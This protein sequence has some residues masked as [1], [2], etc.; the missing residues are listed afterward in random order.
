MLHCIPDHKFINPKKRETSG[1]AF[2]AIKRARKRQWTEVGDAKKI[3]G[4][5]LQWLS[6]NGTRT[7]KLLL[8]V[9][10]EIWQG[11][12]DFHNVDDVRPVVDVFA[13]VSLSL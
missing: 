7:C 4:K 3:R 11:E 1:N 10:H 5:K 8:A 6:S 12:H 2:A 9:T 13:V